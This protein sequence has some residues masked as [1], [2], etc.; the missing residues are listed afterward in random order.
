MPAGRR[1]KKLDRETA[2]RSGRRRPRAGL[3]RAARGDPELSRR[4]AEPAAI[5]GDPSP[6]A[7]QLG[8]AVHHTARFTVRSE[9][10]YVHAT[11]GAISPCLDGAWRIRPIG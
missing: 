10:L 1:G 8:A 7:A 6:V 11:A 9:L 5:K 3:W 4:Y 2:A